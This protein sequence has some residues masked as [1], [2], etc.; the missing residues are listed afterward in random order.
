MKNSIQTAVVAVFL[1][2]LSANA[3]ITLSDM[4]MSNTDGVVYRVDGTTLQA[5]EA[6][7]FHSTGWPN[8]QIEYLGD[9]I[10]AGT[11]SNHVDT[12]NTI[13][14]TQEHL[15]NAI[16]FDTLGE[17]QI[18]NTSGLAVLDN[19]SIM[20]SVLFWVGSALYGG[21]GIY[22][23]SS[24]TVST[25][26]GFLIV[27]DLH[28]IEGSLT[29]AALE[30]TASNR[31]SIFDYEAELLIDSYTIDTPI[32]SFI[33]NNGQLLVLSDNG[34]LY[35]FD[36]LTGALSLHGTI[37]GFE[38]DSNSITIPSQSSIAMLGLGMLVCTKRR[39]ELAV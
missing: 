37:T 23:P 11:L 17:A 7:Q 5:T 10:V 33:E 1:A 38:G 28:Q 20:T 30:T 2:P 9:G 24:Q 16:D 31:I 27:N 19:G 34:E 13:T 39:R 8:L 18:A 36:Y 14:G 21:T 26:G 6:F 15:F 22:D 4:Y 35:Q 29:L 32:N 12:Y 3:G 25:W